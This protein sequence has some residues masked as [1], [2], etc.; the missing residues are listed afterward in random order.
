MLRTLEVVFDGEVLR[1]TEHLDLLPNTR[2]QIVFDV[3][4][5][6]EKSRPSFVQTGRSLKLDGPPDWS[7][8]SRSVAPELQM[9]AG[10]EIVAQRQIVQIYSP[11][12]RDRAQISAFDLIE[13][14]GE[15]ENGL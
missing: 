12:L 6:R 11:R 8:N 7:E 14:V 13:V 1:P 15:S 4:D 3:P 2:M 5:M 9:D 10:E